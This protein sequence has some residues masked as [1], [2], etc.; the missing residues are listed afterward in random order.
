MGDFRK[1]A[2]DISGCLFKSLNKKGIRREKLASELG[3]SVNQLKN[4]AYDSTKSATLENFLAAMI[5]YKCVD[6]LDII[7]KD[8]DCCVYRPSA[9]QVKNN[10]T[11]IAAEVLAETAKAVA[12]YMD[13]N[14]SKE[15]IAVSIRSSIE[16]L[17]ILEM[18]L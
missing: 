4:Y 14:K 1:Y 12:G 18:E 9:P 17:I 3:I 6:V 7:A 8:M 15:E 13:K 5:K 2:C 11:D 10:S 16:K